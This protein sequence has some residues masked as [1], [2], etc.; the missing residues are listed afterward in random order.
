MTLNLK[1][2]TEKREEVR[3]RAQVQSGVTVSSS[4]QLGPRVPEGERQRIPLGKGSQII[5]SIGGPT[6]GSGLHPEITGQPPQ[7]FQQG[8][9][10]LDPS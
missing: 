2:A 4:G 10:W 1:R 7:M 5:R 6:G 9:T 3:G 8:A